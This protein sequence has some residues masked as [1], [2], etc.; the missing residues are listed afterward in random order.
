MNELSLLD[1]CTS[2]L[3]GKPVSLQS[4]LDAAAPVGLNSL[5]C[6]LLLSHRSSA[7]HVILSTVKNDKGT[8]TADLL[9]TPD[10]ADLSQWINYS[11]FIAGFQGVNPIAGTVPSPFPAAPVTYDFEW[12]LNGF[13]AFT[14]S[15]PN[16]IARFG[17]NPIGFGSG[18]E[19][20][21]LI[22]LGGQSFDARVLGQRTPYHQYQNQ[23]R[24]AYAPG[25]A[26]MT[27]TVNGSNQLTWHDS[28]LGTS[29]SQ[30]Q[31]SPAASINCVVWEC[32]PVI[33]TFSGET[34]S[35]TLASPFTPDDTPLPGLTREYSY[36]D[37]GSV[38]M[39]AYGGNLG[40][41]TYPVNNLRSWFVLYCNSAVQSV[42]LNGVSPASFAFGGFSAI[43]PYFA[44]PPTI[45]VTQA[46]AWDLS[47]LTN[48]F[49]FQFVVNGQ[50]LVPSTK[51]IGTTGIPHLFEAFA[52]AQ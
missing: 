5:G 21:P 14:D 38:T 46:F 36:V 47:Y 32:H 50:T 51:T 20:Y 28:G 18:N 3:K 41:I 24:I 7:G 26:P 49:A 31:G 16:V 8:D 43:V 4:P 29:F 42:T 10:D 22:N 35:G 25:G 33:T 27:L 2:P 23:L 1:F 40:G 45:A 30:S 39:P 9:T 48:S 44:G 12:S 19:S 6:N 15:N 17:E 34:E 13:V 11:A 52:F 37:Y